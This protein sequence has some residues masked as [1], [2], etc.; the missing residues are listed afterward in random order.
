MFVDSNKKYLLIGLN[1]HNHNVSRKSS[2]NSFLRIES[3]VLGAL[4][5]LSLPS[6]YVYSFIKM[7]Q[8]KM[9]PA[10]VT[11]AVGRALL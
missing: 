6:I 9:R 10:T 8:V 7:L 2:I 3:L 1:R 4:L 5:S 11:C